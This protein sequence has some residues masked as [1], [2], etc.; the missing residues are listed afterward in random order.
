MEAS[1]YFQLVVQYL[2]PEEDPLVSFRWTVGE[3]INNPKFALKIYH[4]L[5]PS[6][7]GIFHLYFHYLLKHRLN[8]VRNLICCSI[9][10]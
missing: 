2:P 7:S 4:V 3:R 6:V 9:R 5:R 1:G 10:K 8:L